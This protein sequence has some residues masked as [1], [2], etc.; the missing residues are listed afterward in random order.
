MNSEQKLIFDCSDALIYVQLNGAIFHYVY[1]CNSTMTDEIN[2]SY[3][4]E[5]KPKYNSSEYKYNVPKRREDATIECRTSFDPVFDGY[6]IWA[7]PC[8]NIKECYDGEDEKNCDFPFWTIPSILF[9]T[10]IVLCLAFAAYLYKYSRQDWNEIMQDR[11]W[12][13]ATRQSTSKESEKGYRIALLAHGEDLA[14]IMNIF[15]S[16]V[17]THG[18]EA[19][20]ICYLKVHTVFFSFKKLTF[21]LT[22]ICQ[23]KAL[24][25]CI[26]VRFYK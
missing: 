8:N 14:G 15:T 12:R 18:S 1:L 5:C 20:A 10:V 26:Q 9:G 19:T 3:K 21:N 4:I 25:E 13:L 2:R 24:K 17:E 6:V 23:I 22:Q 7:V 11:R 16:E